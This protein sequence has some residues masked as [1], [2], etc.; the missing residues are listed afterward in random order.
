MEALKATVDGKG[1]FLKS[2]FFWRHVTTDIPGPTT[3]LQALTPMQANHS[4][5]PAV[6]IA[7]ITLN[8]DVKMIL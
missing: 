8:Q 3:K 1:I 6:A 4:G 5:I 7:F 2:F